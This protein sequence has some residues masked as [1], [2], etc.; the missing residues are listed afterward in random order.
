M[1]RA[2]SCP[3]QEGKRSED[4]EAVGMLV[5]CPVY[6]SMSAPKAEL[7][8]KIKHRPEEM[9]EE[10]EQEV[11]ALVSGVCKP[12]KFDKYKMFIKDMDT[13]V[14]L[15]LFFSGCL[16]RVENVLGGL[17]EDASKE[18]RSS[19]NEKRKDYQHFVKMK[20]TL[21]T[22]QQ[23]LD[24]KTKLGQKQDKCL[25]ESLPLDFIPKEGTLALPPDLTS[26]M[27][28][29][30]ECTSGGVFPPVTSPI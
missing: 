21:L 7:L 4:K 3:G 25:L 9:N 16:A 8:N 2:I 5:N 26:K 23:E 27:S 1:Q 19:L 29:V 15:L 13:V 10:E 18:E 12:N 24:D 30:G 17:G 14:S 28:P 22:E 6:Y 20:S 11:E